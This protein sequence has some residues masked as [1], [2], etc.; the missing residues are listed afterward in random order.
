MPGKILDQKH[1]YRLEG[2]NHTEIRLIKFVRVRILSVIRKDN[3]VL[4]FRMLQRSG[5]GPL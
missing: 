3:L 2:P 1:E 5:L 4:K